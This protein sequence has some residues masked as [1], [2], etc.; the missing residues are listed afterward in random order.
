MTTSLS[1]EFW[2]LAHG[3]AQSIRQHLHQHTH[4]S[5]GILLVHALW[6]ARLCGYDR[7]AVVEFGVAS[8]RGIT[9]LRQYINKFAPQFG[10]TVDLI[11]FDSGRGLPPVR[12]YRD[13]P[14]I[15]QQGEYASH[16]ADPAVIFGDVSVT[17]PQLVDSWPDT[18][19]AFVSLDLDLY[20]STVSALQIFQ[21]PPDRYLPTVLVHLDDAHTHLT[22]NPWCGAELAICEFNSKHHLR[23]IEQ[24]HYRWNLDNF[25]AMHVLDHPFR[26]GT[27]PPMSINCSP[28]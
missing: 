8:G 10:V 18:K 19:L 13:H 6:Q 14:E 4:P 27:Q 20:S 5:Y 17:L 2:Q 9:A 26:N 22:M 16:C 24:K 23:K 1:T 25:Y 15:W 3:C 11:G 21:M 12:D 7:I 28:I